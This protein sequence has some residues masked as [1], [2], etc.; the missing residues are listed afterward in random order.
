VT[1]APHDS[2]SLGP[3]LV[4]LGLICQEVGASIA[5][6]LFPTVGPVGMVALR[7]AISAL[8]LLAVARPSLRRTGRT[9]WRAAAGFGLVLAAMNAFFY[10]SLERLPLGAAVTIETLGPLALSVAAGRRWRSLAW[11]A[12]AAAG[13][14]L[15]GGGLTDLD[16]LGVAL[17]L[18]AAALWA[19]ILLSRAAG[20]H[21]DGVGGL[22]VATAVGAVITIPVA[23]AA[24]GPSALLQPGVLAAGLGIAVLSTA[25]P[26]ALELTA[27]RRTPV[28]TVAVL[29]ALAPAVA[30]AAGFVVLGQALT[31]P[32]LIGIAFVVAA[33]IGAVRTK[34]KPRT[35]SA[36]RV[37]VGQDSQ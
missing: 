27:L 7:L 10:L 29:L 3:W 35:A 28:D 22:A 2:P 9:A 12:T 1:P 4:L 8:L 19:Y 30:A 5:V 23:A 20:A 37:T 17:A 33:G 34:P 32:A 13:V 11:A 26:Y 18:A 16:P 31:L 24:V 15:L 21:F 14:A 6:T 25:I 36:G